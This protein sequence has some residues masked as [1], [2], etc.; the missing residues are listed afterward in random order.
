MEQINAEKLDL[1]SLTSGDRTG[2]GV[3]DE[4]M[5]AVKSH[6]IEEHT[7][8][9]ITGDQYSRAVTIAIGDVLVNANQ[10]TLQHLITNQTIR[11]LD[12]EIEAAKNQ[13]E[14][15][16]AQVLNIEAD[17]RLKE[18]SIIHTTAQTANVEQQ[19]LNAVK[20]GLLIDEQI[21]NVAA[22]T[23]IKTNQGLAIIEQTKLTVAQT[24]NAESENTVITNSGQK[25]L[26][27]I[28]VLEQKAITEEAQTKDL[29]DGVAVG[30]VI[31]KQIT[32]Y[33]NQAEGYIRDAEQKAAKFYTDMMATRVSV[34]EDTYD[35]TTAKMQNEQ[36]AQVLDVMRAGVGL[37]PAV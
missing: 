22:D 10:F 6:L 5:R 18:A 20:Q 1:R 37:G 11:K 29:V 15:I 4:L 25:I 3:Y 23:V 34:D 31:G 28:K 30:G 13:A 19:T 21:G 33:T 35:L 27:E 17:T 16:A 14:L 32:L 12:W 36:V 24:S 7:Q 9:R 2:S 8:G 26:S